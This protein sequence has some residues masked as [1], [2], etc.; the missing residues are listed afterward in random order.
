MTQS[1]HPAAEKGF[2]AAAALYQQVRPDYPA[3]I[4]IWLQ[5]QLNLGPQDALLDLGAG[6]GK[7]LPYLK[8]ISACIT[9]VEPVPAMLQQLRQAHP[10]INTVQAF[11]S[12]IPVPDH[13]IRAVFCA[14]SF[15]W[16]ADRATLAEIQRIL[17]PHGYLVLIWNQRDIN[18]D[19]VKA[20]ADILLPLEGS[21]PRYHSGLWQKAF[22]QQ[23]WFTLHQE[24]A[25]RQLHRGTVEQVVSKRLLSTSFIAAMPEAQQQALK[26]QFEQ[27][28]FE[29][30]GKQAQDE[31]EF[32]YTTHVYVFQKTAEK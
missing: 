28:V 2:G 24:T 10:D 19:W 12:Q 20:L 22:E 31:I 1:L 7:F 21:T 32:P 5:Q 11:S 3:E 30:T 23:P 15:H 29:L 14:Q 25:F 18:T 9:A 13:S 17:Q 4:S 16:F 6:T 8:P 27:T 26:L